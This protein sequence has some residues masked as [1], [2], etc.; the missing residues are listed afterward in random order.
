ML[1]QGGEGRRRGSEAGR[2]PPPPAEAGER[3]AISSPASVTYRVAQPQQ[4]RSQQQSSQ[5]WGMLILLPWSDQGARGGAGTKSPHDVGHAAVEELSRS[6]KPGR[7]PVGL[8]HAGRPMNIFDLRD[9][10]GEVEGIAEYFRPVI[11]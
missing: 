4:W 10:Y 1:K 9:I 3:P 8:S 11:R 7:P 2:D 6:G 5:R